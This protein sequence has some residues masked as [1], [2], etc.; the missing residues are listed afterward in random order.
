MRK[1]VMTLEALEV[2]TFAIDENL[3]RHAGTVRAEEATPNCTE[4]FPCVL[5]TAD[6]YDYR[7]YASLVPIE[8]PGPGEA[9]CSSV[10]QSSPLQ[11]ATT[12]FDGCP[13]T[14]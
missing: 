9:N 13:L 8:T 10:C 5:P 4:D 2:E 6:P 12:V 3:P 14:Q 1:I 11:C 7:C